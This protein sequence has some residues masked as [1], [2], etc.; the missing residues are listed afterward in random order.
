[1]IKSQL[2]S[3][4]RTRDKVYDAGKRATTK[5]YDKGKD[6]GKKGLM[7]AL[8]TISQNTV[9]GIPD[10]E[11]IK[12]AEVKEFSSELK[13]VQLYQNLYTLF[14]CIGYQESTKFNLD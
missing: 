11:E 3:S 9:G 1:M 8:N 7:A 5:I 6:I 4:T 13:W 14:S 10:N 12:V 2:Q